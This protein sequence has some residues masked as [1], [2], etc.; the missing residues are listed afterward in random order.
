[1]QKQSLELLEQ[2]KE[3][4]ESYDFA[5]TL[6]QIYYQLVAKQ[7]IPN[8]QKYYMKLSRLC[9]IGRDE[10]ILPED[11]FADRLRQVDKLASYID[12][13]D[14]M[15]T[16]R[17]AYRKDKWADQDAYIE[18]WTEKDALRGVITPVTY[19]YDVALLIVRGQVSR[20]AIYESYERFA[21]KMEEG[22]DCY[23]CYFGDFD[24]SG[25]SI[26]HSLKER[27]MSYGEDG[28]RINFERIALTPGQIEEYSLPSDPAKQAD[29]NYKRF[30]AEYGDNVVELDA[31]PPD[32]LKELVLYCIRTK[33]NDELLAQVQEVELAERAKL[34]ELRL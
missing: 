19:A 26:Y 14:F 30:V 33:L 32:V 23:L 17:R 2:V 10:G 3:I 28:D 15:T 7:I 25:L 8:Q 29:P 4:I 5:L 22:K 1:M 6:R 31:L 34:Q 9:V 13:A 12:L 18:I 27:L 24:P 21:E 11:A 20:T 16:V